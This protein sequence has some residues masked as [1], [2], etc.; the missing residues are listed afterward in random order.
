[1]TEERY[2]LYIRDFNAACAGDGSG[3]GDFFDKYYE[4]DAVFEYIPN[5][6][7][8]I[9]RDVVVAFWE[10]VH[11]LMH[12]EIK[13]HRTFLSSDTTVAT[14]APIDFQCKKD[15]EWVGVKHKAG[16]TFRLM[17]SAFYDLSENGKFKYVRVYSVYHPDYQ[18][19]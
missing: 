8:N 6:T 11:G 3:F 9:G 16:D 15:M 7:K 19:D 5:A 2:N 18:P 13:P 12:E 17:M 10:H 14:E 1:M 4:P